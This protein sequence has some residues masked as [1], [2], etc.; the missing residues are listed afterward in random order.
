MEIQK[1]FKETSWFKDDPRWHIGKRADI[2]ILI[3]SI[4]GFYSE[5]ISGSVDV[6]ET[7]TIF[8]NGETSCGKTWLSADSDWPEN[9]IW[10]YCPY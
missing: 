1:S 7:F 10:S 4:N 5:A 8:L 6:K 9:W 3:K 2:V